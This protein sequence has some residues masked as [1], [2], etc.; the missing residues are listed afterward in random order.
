MSRNILYSA[1]LIFVFVGCG[2]DQI[3]RSGITSS[4][5][6]QFTV[7]SI[8][9]GVADQ[10]ACVGL[11][12][13]TNQ[14]V[15]HLY[16][17][18]LSW[19][20]SFDLSKYSE[21][22]GNLKLTC[23]KEDGWLISS[24]K[25]GSPPSLTIYKTNTNFDISHRYDFGP[26]LDSNYKATVRELR[27][28]KNGDYIVAI[29]TVVQGPTRTEFGGVRI[30]RFSNQLSLKYSLSDFGA[31]RVGHYAPR[32]LELN[33][34]SLFYALGTTIAYLNGIRSD[35]T[36][37]RI[38]KDGNILST[39]LLNPAIT[40]RF[41]EPL[42]LVIKG[43]AV[44]LH[45]RL[46]FETQSFTQMN[47][48]TG[49]FINEV[50]LKN[51][52]INHSQTYGCY[53]NYYPF[54]V[55][56][57]KSAESNTVSTNGMTDGNLLFSNSAKQLYF[58]EMSADLSLRRKFDMVLPEFNQIYS[59]RQL[60]TSDNGIIVGASYEYKDESIFTLQEYSSDGIVVS[61]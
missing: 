44:V 17:R 4:H 29:D 50:T 47:A 21:F 5:L 2:D 15:V 46:N 39:S 14:T 60:I 53:E 6:D 16:N 20:K 35:A 24:F 22:R 59:Y 52:E 51:S 27:Q 57:F 23:L 49:K 61:R 54:T 31:Y 1:C 45:S 30:M 19:N 37:G 10:I 28:L 48:S 13:G 43:N 7:T 32:I 58:L 25:E 3:N 9:P 18:D 38:D 40:R 12:R 34:E 56:L 36:V 11:I 33:D 41:V 55:E 8:Q 26:N 42:G